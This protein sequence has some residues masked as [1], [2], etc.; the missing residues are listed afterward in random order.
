MK[1]KVLSALLS[2][3]LVVSMLAG[4]TRSELCSRVQLRTGELCIF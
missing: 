2:A 1:K 3:T 4:H